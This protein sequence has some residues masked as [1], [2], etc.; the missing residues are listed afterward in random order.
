M[1]A[2][3]SRFLFVWAHYSLF[4]A[5]IRLQRMNHGPSSVPRRE[6]E[7]TPAKISRARK[8]ERRSDEAALPFK[9]DF[10]C[11]PHDTETLC[12]HPSGR[13]ARRYCH[14]PS[15][16]APHKNY[17]R[18]AVAPPPRLQTQTSL[19]STPS[20]DAM[21]VAVTQSPRQFV[22]VWHMSQNL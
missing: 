9:R 10:I 2:F 21:H 16:N 13:P 22:G 20:D 19:S 4:K 15:S 14:P 8:R 7:I 6:I 11:P 18:L 5:R 1:A 12:R 17:E 3:Y